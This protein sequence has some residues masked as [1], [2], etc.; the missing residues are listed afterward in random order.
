MEAM[1][2]R[3]ELPLRLLRSPKAGPTP[4]NMARNLH[5][6]Q[7][8]MVLKIAQISWIMAP[9]TSTTPALMESTTEVSYFQPIN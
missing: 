6:L 1:S 2:M 4:V 9:T 3:R 8:P 7:S 5:N